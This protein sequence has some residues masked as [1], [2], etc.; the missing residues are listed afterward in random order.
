MTDFRALCAEL[1]DELKYQTD[2]SIAEELKER[3]CTA[4]AE[5]KPEGPTT[6][7]KK[8]LSLVCN[9]YM[10]GMPPNPHQDWQAYFDHCAATG[11]ISGLKLE[12][13][14]PTPSVNDSIP[15]SIPQQSEPEELQP[16]PVSERLPMDEDCD[17]EGRCWWW[18]PSHP[19]SGCSEGWMQGSRQW[20][21]VR[22]DFDDALVYTHWL[23]AHALPQ[24]S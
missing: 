14:Q 3:A 16:V 10:K 19:E 15:Y 5:P 20:G 9:C 8:P 4:L 23:P 21:A 17:K 11:T 22:Y 2:W 1:L 24:P 18:H 7:G 13:I 12:A 6:G